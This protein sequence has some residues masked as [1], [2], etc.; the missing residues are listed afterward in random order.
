MNILFQYF[1]GGGGALSNIIQLLRTLAIKYP[2]DRL[3]IVCSKL[4]LFNS[5]D[6]LNNV[7]VHIYSCFGYKEIDRLVLGCSEINKLSRKFNS[8]VIWSMNLGSYSKT[9]IPHILSVNNPHQVYPHKVNRYHPDNRFH[10]A[11]LRAFFRRSLSISSG[12]IVQTTL[13]KK[14]ISKLK[15]DFDFIEVIPKAVENESDIIFTS[16]SDQ[17]TSK[18]EFGLGRQAFTFLYVSTLMPHKNHITLIKAFSLIASKG[19]NIRVALT[20]TEKQLIAIGGDKA[21]S[22]LESGHILALGWVNKSS[23]KALYDVCEACL[24]PSLLESLSS[25]HLEAMTWGKPQIISDLPYAKD[26]CGDAAVYVESKDYIAWAQNI[27]KF[28]ED[29]NLR[30]NLVKLGYVR[31]DNLPRNWET[32]AEKVHNYFDKI[33]NNFNKY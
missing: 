17:I 26:L 14:Y 11:I 28:V 23:L 19:L 9:S 25:A 10:V 21:K 7:T 5:L 15:F 18:L 27:E 1:S 16:L 30:N 31:M 8:D 20:I 24:M 6:D 12:V 4:S 13:M 2:K 22:L 33:I 3:D 29:S 32:V